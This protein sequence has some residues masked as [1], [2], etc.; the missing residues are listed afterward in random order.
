MPTVAGSADFCK[1]AEGCG[2]K[3]V[4]R[5][6][7]EPELQQVL[8]DMADEKKSYMRQL[9]FI[10]VRC[11]IGSR[12]DLGRPDISPRENKEMFMGILK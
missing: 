9:T 5:V 11:A 1:I 12:A 7:T 8:F 3:N 6:E 4:F 10:E 2:Y